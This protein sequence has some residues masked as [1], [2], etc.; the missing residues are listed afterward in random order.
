MGVITSSSCWS[1]NRYTAVARRP[2]MGRSRQAGAQQVGVGLVVPEV[3]GVVQLGERLVGASPDV[4][5][6]TERPFA[7]HDEVRLVAGVGNCR[8]RAAG[9]ASSRSTTTNGCCLRRREHWLRATV[10]VA[11]PD[12][13]TDRGRVGVVESTEYSAADVNDLSVAHVVGSSP[14]GTPRDRRR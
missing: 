6:G 9:P 4:G 11:Q 5:V 3:D 1:P 8:T 13:R 7:V 12:R 2:V 14:A 10:G